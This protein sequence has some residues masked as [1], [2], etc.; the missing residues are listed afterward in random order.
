V[1][2][3]PNSQVTVASHRDDDGTTLVQASA[4][5]G[6]RLEPA[7]GRVFCRTELAAAIEEAN[8]YA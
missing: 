5:V 1:F 3:A 7:S 4:D 8:R 2:R 6:L